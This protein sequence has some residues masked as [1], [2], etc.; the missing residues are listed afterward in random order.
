MST[1]LAQLKGK[2]VLSLNNV[3]KVRKTFSQFKIKEVKILYS[4]NASNN[5]IPGKE[6]II[7]T[8]DF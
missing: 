7:T 6:L 8:C 1:L 3:L 5:A 4:C 2:F